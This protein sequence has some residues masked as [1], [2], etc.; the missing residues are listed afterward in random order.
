[1]TTQEVFDKV[2]T[3]LLTQNFKSVDDFGR[4]C[5]YRGPEGTK[6]AVGILIPDEQYN[7]SMEH[8]TVQT[9]IDKFPM[10]EYF[11]RDKIMLIAL[12]RIHDSDLVSTWKL[13]LEIVSV[14]Y[15]LEM[16]IVL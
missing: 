11:N 5:L 16:P 4:C 12:Q 2:A 10:P 14:V 15:N 13:Q 3:H 1:M 9:L 7:P 8:H 6:C